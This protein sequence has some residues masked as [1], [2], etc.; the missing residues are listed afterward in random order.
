MSKCCLC[1]VGSVRS[2]W[3]VCTFLALSVVFS[4]MRSSSGCRYSYLQL[5]IKPAKCFRI[6]CTN[7][8]STFGFE[9]LNSVK[10]IFN[11]RNE[12]SIVI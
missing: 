7:A 5:R 1:C 9:I 8:A 4:M 12:K 3:N 10:L 2:L 11:L 6:F